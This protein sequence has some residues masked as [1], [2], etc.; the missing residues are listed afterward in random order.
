MN[1]NNTTS[2]L[3]EVDIV[4]GLKQVATR[5][6][7]KRLGK[8]IKIQP[9][10]KHDREREVIRF[11]YQGNLTRILQLKTVLSAYLVCEF[12]SSHPSIL[13]KPASLQRLSQQVNTVKALASANTYKSFGCIQN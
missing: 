6:L 8:R 5:E 4:V 2:Y 13:L 9:I 12:A 11:V 7:I 3:C 10:V 1:K